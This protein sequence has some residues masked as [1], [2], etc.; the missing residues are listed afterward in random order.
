L[1]G[2]SI[3]M[4]TADP[5]LSRR[6]ETVQKA[7]AL[8]FNYTIE[9]TSRSDGETTMQLLGIR[10]FNAAASGIKLALSGYYQTA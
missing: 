4:V 10:L 3:A 7:M 1:S 8:I 6:L 2:E 9:H 5:E